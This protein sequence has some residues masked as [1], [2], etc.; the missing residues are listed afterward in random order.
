MLL[1][2]MKITPVVGFYVIYYLYLGLDVISGVFAIY[3]AIYVIT[4]NRLQ[5]SNSLLACVNGYSI[6]LIIIGQ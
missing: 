3:A 2:S 4:V 5:S 6:R 1:A